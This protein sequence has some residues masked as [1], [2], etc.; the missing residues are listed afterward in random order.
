MNRHALIITHGVP[1]AGGPGVQRVLKFVKHLPGFGWH[2][3]VFTV[4]PEAI[5]RYHR[6]W[7]EGVLDHDPDWGVSRRFTRL[8]LTER[9]ARTFERI[10]DG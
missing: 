10:V 1:P 6:A 9:L 4:K 5:S 2:P 3:V 8:R 7:K